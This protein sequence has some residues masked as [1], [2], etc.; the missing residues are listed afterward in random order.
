M[1]IKVWLGI[2]RFFGIFCAL[3][4]YSTIVDMKNISNPSLVMFPYIFI[5]I[6]CFSVEDK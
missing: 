1:R 2:V 6:T 3:C 5:A 4:A